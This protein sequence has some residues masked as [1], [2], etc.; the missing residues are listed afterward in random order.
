M[1]QLRL[2][3]FLLVRCPRGR[4]SSALFRAYFSNLLIVYAWGSMTRVAAQGVFAGFR[5]RLGDPA[6][7]FGLSPRAPGSEGLELLRAIS[8]SVDLLLI[9]D[10]LRS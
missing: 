6:A 5:Q 7:A 3:A 9:T 10:R 2:L 1:P 8:R 4:L